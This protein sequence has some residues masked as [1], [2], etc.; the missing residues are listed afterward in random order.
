MLTFV[1]DVYGDTC[2]SDYPYRAIDGLP[3]TNVLGDPFSLL[4]IGQVDLSYDIP[5][6]FQKL[7]IKR[8]LACIMD[9][10]LR[11]YNVTMNAGVISIQSSKISDGVVAI[12]SW[13]DTVLP[14]WPR[15]GANACGVLSYSLSSN[16][17]AAIDDPSLHLYE[18]AKYCRN[19]RI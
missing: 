18:N 13:N 17:N 16:S 3:F 5:V 8:A 15:T 9:P 10:C 4:N 2:Q 6:P 7:K 19:G 11:E 14:P 1:W 12:F